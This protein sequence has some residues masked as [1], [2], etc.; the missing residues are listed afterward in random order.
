MDTREDE[1]FCFILGFCENSFQKLSFCLQALPEG[2]SIPGR[3]HDIIMLG[4]HGPG[5]GDVLPV[6]AV[7]HHSRLPAATFRCSAGAFRMWKVRFQ[8]ENLTLNPFDCFKSCVWIQQSS[9]DQHPLGPP[10]GAAALRRVHGSQRQRLLPPGGSFREQQLRPH[11]GQ[12]A[13]PPPRGQRTSAAALKSLRTS[14]LRPLLP[15]RTRSAWT[16][17]STTLSR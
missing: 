17:G 3:G 13:Q 6:H 15:S 11:I 4:L 2:K 10:P 12:P 5:H 7:S 16:G 9:R 1:F 8:E 14:P